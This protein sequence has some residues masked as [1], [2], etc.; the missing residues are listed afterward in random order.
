MATMALSPFITYSSESLAAGS[1]QPVPVVVATTR[2][3]R[4][5]PPARS[6]SRTAS[7]ARSS[8]SSADARPV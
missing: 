8:T 5:N 2:T 3:S 6:S 1:T 4:S 7:A